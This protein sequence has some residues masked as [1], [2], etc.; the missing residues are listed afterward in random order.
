MEPSWKARCGL[1]FASR[2]RTG[3]WSDTRSRVTLWGH[4]YCTSTGVRVRG[5]RPVFRGWVRQPTT[6]GLRVLTPDRPGMGLTAFRRYSVTDYPRLVR[7]F[8][9][10]LGLGRFAVIG[11]SGGG[12]YACACAWGLPDRVTRVALVS[13]TCS[14]DLPGARETWSR[15][16]RRLYRL[17]DRAPWLMRL[18]LAKVGR[19]L[20][21]DPNAMFSTVAR[22][23]GPADRDVL[24][25]PGYREVLNRNM[26]E[27]FRQGARG[28]AYDLTLEARPWGVPFDSIEV[29][30]EIWHGEDDRVVSVEQVRILARALPLVTEHHVPGEGHFSVFARHAGE[31]LQSV[32]AP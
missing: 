28:P 3:P 4:R 32:M 19:D 6:L 23:V 8:A 13:S 16:D 18:F 7:S 5:W 21:R 2:Y 11:V 9:D 27:A 31:I 17:A 10:A 12:K 15:E 22:T 26:G 30:I 25:G 29:P 14:F 1:T 20:R 24:A